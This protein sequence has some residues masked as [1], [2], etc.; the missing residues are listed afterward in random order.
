MA[1]EMIYTGKMVSAAEGHRMGLVNKVTAPE[2]LMDEVMQA[3]KEI[4]AKG[5]VSLRAAKQAINHGINAD[6][7]TGLNIEIDAFALS[8]SSADAKEGTTAFLEK[9][10]PNFT[11]KLNELMIIS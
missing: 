1:K 6:L 5:K 8:F 3:A 4:A 9:R 7:T 2:S 11:G 10:K